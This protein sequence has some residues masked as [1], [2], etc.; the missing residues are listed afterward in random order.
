MPNWRCRAPFR[1]KRVSSSP[2][3]VGRPGTRRLEVTVGGI[4]W[5]YRDLI[6]PTADGTESWSSALAEDGSLVIHFR[7]RLP[8]GT[9]NVVVGRHRV[10]VGP[11]GSVPARAFTKPM[12]KHRYIRAV[13]QPLAATGGAEREPL[14]DIRTNASSRL[15]ANG[16]AV[17]LRDFE[18]LCQRRTDIWQASA[19]SITD[20][21]RS[22][23]VGIVLVPA[24]G[25]GIGATLRDELTEFVEARSLPGI[26]V[27]F[28]LYEHIGLLISATVR[29]DYAKYDRNEVQAAAQ[30]ALIDSFAL[31]RR[32]LGQA[33]YIAEATAVLERVTGVETAIIQDFAVVDPTRLQRTASTDG[34][35]S[36]FFPAR[37]QV[38]AARPASAFADMAV[39]LE[40]L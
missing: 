12:K 19:Y 9:D 4:G 35:P 24:N 20:P 31:Q 25:G 11:T 28:E 14:E 18:R 26:R 8:T 27:A 29:V 22:E 23:N 38:I 30:A 33:I 13:T 7:R 16:R 15:I 1:A 36:A 34:R 40:A 5:S 39:R 10:G 17:S 3:R 32:G 37:N 2:R 21:G 6:D